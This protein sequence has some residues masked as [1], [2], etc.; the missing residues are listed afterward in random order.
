MLRP[1]HPQAIHGNVTGARSATAAGVAI[2]MMVSLFGQRYQNKMIRDTY[3]HHIY[4]A[5]KQ[6]I[7]LLNF[8][9][10]ILTLDADWLKGGQPVYIPHSETRFLLIPFWILLMIS[11]L[12]SFSTFYDFQ[13]V[14][15]TIPYFTISALV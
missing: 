8:N 2:S 3:K 4:P 9:H 13:F 11:S 12:L 5:S 1:V 6:N 14:P 15:S 7:F 10:V